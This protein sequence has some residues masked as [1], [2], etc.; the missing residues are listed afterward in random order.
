MKLTI[1]LQVT[2]DGVA[3]ANGGNNEDLDPGFTRGGWALP[4]GDDE[5]VQ[6]ILDTWRRPDRFLMGRKTF[7]MFATF[8]GA[9]SDDGGFGEAISSKPKYVVS[10]TLI[11][12]AWEQSTVISGDVVAEIR[13]IKA[14]HVGELLLVGSVRLA[15]WLLDNE[16]V[17]ELNLVQF[18]VIVGEGERLFPQDGLDIRLELL[19]SQ[20]FGTGVIGLTYRVAG[21]PEYA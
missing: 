21:R 19:D 8:W 17:D 15:R 13:E 5:S 16:L 9:R 6:Y 1:S 7:D 12:P 14:Q 20:V 3:Q 18:P 4:L 11:N 2:L 10:N